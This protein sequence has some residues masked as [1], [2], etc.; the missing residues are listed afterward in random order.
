MDALPAGSPRTTGAAGRWDIGLLP[1]EWAAVVSELKKR[2]RPRSPSFTM[3][4]AVMNTFENPNETI[5]VPDIPLN[6][7]VNVIIRCDNTTLDVYINGT[8]IKRHQLSGVPKQNYDDVYMAA[9]GGFSGY[10]SNLWYYNYALGTSAIETIVENGPNLNMKDK[11]MLQS[12][13]YY[14]SL[15]WFFAGAGD[16]YFPTAYTDAGMQRMDPSKPADFGLPQAS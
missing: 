15:R 5:I 1:S 7:W 4:V 14:L 12:E 2:P 6:K 16:E 10:I 8:V 3:P 9:N 11:D 13:P